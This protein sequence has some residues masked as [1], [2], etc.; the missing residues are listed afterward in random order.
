MQLQEVKHNC[1]DLWHSI[2]RQMMASREVCA[3]WY[4]FLQVQVL[5]VG[6]GGVAKQKPLALASM[7]GM[8]LCQRCFGKNVGLK[9]WRKLLANVS[10][11]E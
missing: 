5:N 10:S 7:C 8:L 3:C 4:G 11:C 2:R 9:L 1:W 6:A